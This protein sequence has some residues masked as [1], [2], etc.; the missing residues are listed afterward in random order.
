MQRLWILQN[1]ADRADDRHFE[2]VQDPRDTEGQDHDE[3]EA[4]PGQAVE[5]RRDLRLD[6][7]ARATGI[8]RGNARGRNEMPPALPLRVNAEAAE[9]SAPVRFL[10]EIL[11]SVWLKF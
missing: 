1:A 6:S 3:V 4:R 9:L 8:A 10:P 11:A 5:P 7:T 2:P